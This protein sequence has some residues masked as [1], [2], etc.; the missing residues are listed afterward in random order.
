[1]HGEV[2]NIVPFHMGEKMYKLANEPKYSYFSKYD[3][4]MMEDNEK[5]LKELNDFIISLN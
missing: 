1:M 3:D 5:L 4:H 2:D